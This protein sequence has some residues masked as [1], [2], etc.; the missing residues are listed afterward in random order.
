[1]T[2]SNYLKPVTEIVYLSL[3]DK[4]LMGGD[5]ELST[6]DQLANQNMLFDGLDDDIDDNSPSDTDKSGLWDE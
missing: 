3:K 5:P 4:L 6:N 1:M 2:E